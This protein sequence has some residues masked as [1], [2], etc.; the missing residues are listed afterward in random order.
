MN[1]NW[2]NKLV[3]TLIFVLSVAVPLFAREDSE[4][5][6]REFEEEVRKIY[7]QPVNTMDNFGFDAYMLKE[8]QGLTDFREGEPEENAKL[9]KPLKQVNGKS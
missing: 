4:K 7:E 6:R 1:A 5:A 9:L 2:L 3:L 8:S